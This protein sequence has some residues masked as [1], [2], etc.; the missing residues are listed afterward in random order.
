MDRR[1]DQLNLAGT[2]RLLR[3]IHGDQFSEVGLAP[4]F[5]PYFNGPRL[6]ISTPYADGTNFVRRGRIGI[7]TGH[8]PVFLLLPRRDSRGSW[9]V[10]NDRDQ[11]VRIIPDWWS[12]R[13]GPLHLPA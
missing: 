5:R 7:S 8:K 10:L 2:L 12:R 11:I 6:E 3:D 1:T 9:D 4:Q 13:W